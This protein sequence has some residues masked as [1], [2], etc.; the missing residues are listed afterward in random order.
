MFKFRIYFRQRIKF[1]WTWNSTVGVTTRY[2]L[3]CPG[4]ESVW[5]RDF[6]LPSRRDQGSTQPPTHCAPGH[7]RE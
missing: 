6:P 3:D 7:S 5:R 1:S 4:I 2:Q